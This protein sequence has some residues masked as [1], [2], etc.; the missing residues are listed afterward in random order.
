[1]AEANKVKKLK[2]KELSTEEFIKRVQQL[3]E[4]SREDV[5]CAIQDDINNQYNSDPV[6]IYQK[7]DRQDWRQ[8]I[9]LTDKDPFCIFISSMSG[10]LRQL[11]EAAENNFKDKLPSDIDVRDRHGDRWNA[12]VFW[13]DYKGTLRL[14]FCGI[15]KQTAKNILD[16]ISDKDC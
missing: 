13:K 6:V 10:K 9:V 8:I 1:V 4:R 7:G 16:A 12:A 11:Q 15:T 3:P 2:P 14:D 5:I